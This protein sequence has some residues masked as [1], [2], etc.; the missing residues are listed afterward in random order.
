MAAVPDEFV[1]LFEGAFIEEQFDALAGR[2]FAFPMLAFPPL[3]AATFF[4]PGV[5]PPHFIQS[6]R[7]HWVAV[8][9]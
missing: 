8:T 9:S 3:L 7:A 4:G 6:V 1:Q 2:Q 5:P